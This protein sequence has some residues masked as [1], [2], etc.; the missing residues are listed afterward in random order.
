MRILQRITNQNHNIMKYRIIITTDPYHASRH[1]GFVLNETRTLGIKTVETAL[2]L[3]EAQDKLLKLFC[4]DAQQYFPNWGVACAWKQGGDL[5]ARP[6]HKDG[7]RTYC[8]DVFSVSIVQ[9]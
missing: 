2:T 4:E 9:E 6:T 5:Y 7:T 8:N 3:K 1:P